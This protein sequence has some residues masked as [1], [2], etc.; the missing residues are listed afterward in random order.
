MVAT[1][2]TDESGPRVLLNLSTMFSG[3]AGTHVAGFLQEFAEAY[4]GLTILCPSVKDLPEIKQLADATILAHGFGPGDPRARL[5]ELVMVQKLKRRND[6]VLHVMNR[7]VSQRG[8]RSVVFCC[9]VLHF[10]RQ[11]RSPV[12]KFNDWLVRR[13]MEAAD[14]CIFPSSSALDH[15]RSAQ[16]SMDRAV[17]IHHPVRLTGGARQPDRPAD[18]RGSLDSRVRVLVPSSAQRH[19]NLDL[20]PE[21]SRFLADQGWSVEFHVTA[22]LDSSDPKVHSAMRYSRNRVAEVASEY[23][24][25]FLPSK[26]ESFSFAPVEFAL[27]GMPV[28]VSDI[29]VHREVVPGARFFNPDDPSD[30]AEQI[31]AEVYGRHRNDQT[32]SPT[33][34]TPDEYVARLSAELEAVW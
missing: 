4:T 24:I 1:A 14:L 28:V 23:D 5:F 16:I 25:C 15:A 26:M 2:A 32:V 31:L 30:A 33:F 17:V 6:V 20:V 34:S 11:D 18:R 3:G 19:K 9:N 22:E 13:S 21:V 12:V 8:C 29:P 10:A 7:G 27:L